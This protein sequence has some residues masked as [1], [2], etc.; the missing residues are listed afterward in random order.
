[1]LRRV[2]DRPFWLSVAELHDDPTTREWLDGEPRLHYIWGGHP[3]GDSPVRYRR[4]D[5]GEFDALCFVR[6]S[7]PYE[8]LG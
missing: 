2:G 3:D 7:S 6:E 1:V 5:L 4:S 8:Q